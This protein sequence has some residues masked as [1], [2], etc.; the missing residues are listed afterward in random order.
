[1]AATARRAAYFTR[2]RRSECI[3]RVQLA[4]A[5][6]DFL[7]LRLRHPRYHR[8]RPARRPGFAWLRAAASIERATLYGLVQRKGAG[9]TRIEIN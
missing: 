9:S 2:S 6:F 1:V 3:S 8:H 4:D 7:R 5:A